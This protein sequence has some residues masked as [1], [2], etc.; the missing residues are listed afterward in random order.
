MNNK[1][2][3]EKP[4]MHAVLAELVDFKRLGLAALLADAD[5]QQRLQ[6]KVE[7]KSRPFAK[8]LLADGLSVIAE[9]KRASP[10]KGKMAT[11]DCPA[12][13]AKSYQEAGASAISVL[14]C[15]KGFLGSNADLI[16]VRNSC[17]LPILRKDFICDPIQLA[18]TQRMGA[19]AVLLMVSVV[20][21][22][23]SEFLSCAE[24]LGLEALVEVKDEYELNIAKQSCAPIIGINSRDLNDFSV[25]DDRFSLIDFFKDS[26][27]EKSDKTIWVAESGFSSPKQAKAAIKHGFNAALVGEAL[28]K[29]N[30]PKKWMMDFAP[31]KI[32]K[33]C[34]MRSVSVVNDLVGLGINKQIDFC[35]II[36]E[37]SSKRY[38]PPERSKELIEAIRNAGI[39]PVV[40]IQS[41][42][43]DDL[44]YWINTYNLTTVQLHHPD[45]HHYRKLLAQDIRCIVACSLETQ[46]SENISKSLLNSLFE[47]DWILLDSKN[48]GSGNT[49]NYDLYK[50]LAAVNTM[51]AGG[52]T[53]ENV[54][55][56]L[57]LPGVNGVDVVSGVE[58]A[59]GDISIDKVLSFVKS[60][61]ET[62]LN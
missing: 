40:V 36:W 5:C 17:E 27:D 32:T 14:T 37:P 20:G 18:E 9:I 45:I 16:A 23:L 13:L 57:L 39:E 7:L 21:E 11:I 19:H 10:S 59:P 48:P 15:E 2:K 4:G 8:A 51:I 50:P 30:S 58:Q 3:Q 41:M 25:D 53:A 22:R 29:T 42:Q 1:S 46:E 38:L 24:N 47:K 60:V 28:V 61:G 35:G 34:G 31:K 6:T 56:A 43:L 55:Q 26:E 52:L 62:Q 12:K 54:S 33:I 44:K 49:F